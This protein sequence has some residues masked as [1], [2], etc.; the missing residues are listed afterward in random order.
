MTAPLRLV[1]V[2]GEPSGDRLG[3]PLIRALK[4]QA[5]R[6]VEVTGVGG[7]L[8]QEAGLVPLFDN[9]ELA[10][11]GLAEVVPKIPSLLARIRQTADH[12]TK[13]RPDAL[14]TVDSPSFGLRVA[15]KAR[16]AEPGLKT[17]HY[18]APSVWANAVVAEVYMPGL[19]RRPLVED[20]RVKSFVSRKKGRVLS[21]FAEYAI[22]QFRRELGKAVEDGPWYRSMR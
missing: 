2:S 22:A 6:E 19:V 8:M 4:A 16:A 5:G 21:G 17:I 7:P 10:V 15:A 1:M 14:I 9:D 12:V 11:M 18:V 3:A 13:V 20:V